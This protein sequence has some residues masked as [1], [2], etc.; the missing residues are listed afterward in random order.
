MI[1]C[2]FLAHALR[3]KQLLLHGYLE[4]LTT[5]PSIF[6]SPYHASHSFSLTFNTLVASNTQHLGHSLYHC[7]WLHF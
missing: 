2:Y 5:E 3:D 6:Y 7:I 4:V 1:L